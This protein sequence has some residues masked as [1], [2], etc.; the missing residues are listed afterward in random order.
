MDL[1]LLSGL[2][3]TAVVLFGL[4]Y[5][6]KELVGDRMARWVAEYSAKPSMDPNSQL[7]GAI[8][9]VVDDAGDGELSVRVG[10]ER[11]NARL[12]AANGRPLPAGTP[13]KVTAVHG[14]VLV[15]EES[16]GAPVAAP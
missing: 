11:W 7:I 1:N 6:I 5:L 15:V 4:G 8:G 10:I 14:L 2:L 9:R 16:P 12:A 3:L 13:V